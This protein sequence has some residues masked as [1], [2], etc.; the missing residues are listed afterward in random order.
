M[1]GFML[2]FLLRGVLGCG[3]DLGRGRV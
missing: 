1:R 3:W 2:E